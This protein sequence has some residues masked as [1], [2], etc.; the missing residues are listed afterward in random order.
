M[1]AVMHFLFLRPILALA[2][3]TEILGFPEIWSG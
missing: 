2:E 3:N 1:G